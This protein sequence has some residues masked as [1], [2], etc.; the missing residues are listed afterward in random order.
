MVFGVAALAHGRA[1]FSFEV[2]RGGIKEHPVQT[3][4]QVPALREQFLLEDV[5]VGAG[6]ERGCAVLLVF[7]EIL[8][9]PSMARYK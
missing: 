3:G 9:Q 8:S 1:A 5:L 7:G 2:D 6:R 4:E